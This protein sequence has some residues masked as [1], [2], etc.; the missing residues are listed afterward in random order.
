M[1]GSQHLPFNYWQKVG[2]KPI[3]LKILPWLLP[4]AFYHLVIHFAYPAYYDDSFIG[5][6]I[7][8]NMAD[9]F[10]LVFNPGELELVNTSFLY[11]FINS[12]WMIL[13]GPKIAIHITIV[14]DILM[15]T[16][17]LAMLGSLVYN[18]IPHTFTRYKSWLQI[19]LLVVLYGTSIRVTTLITAGM[20]SQLYIFFII[21]TFFLHAKG[22]EKAAYWIGA[23]I[24]LIRPE[25]VF[26]NLALGICYIFEKRKFPT[27]LAV[28]SIFVWACFLIY[29]L[30]VY[31][32]IFPLSVE[33]KRGIG[34]FTLDFKLRF[35]NQMICYQY[36]GLLKY[37]QVLL[38]ILGVYAV[39]TTSRLRPFG[40]WWLFYF[41]F[42]GLVANFHYVWY[43]TAF[44]M[45]WYSLSLIGALNTSIMLEKN[46]FKTKLIAGLNLS[47][48][49]MILFSIAFSITTLKTARRVIPRLLP[50]SKSFAIRVRQ[51]DDVALI[52]TKAPKGGYTLLEPLGLLGYAM[53]NT[54]FAD[55]PGLCSPKV[56]K[57]HKELGRLLL[58][59]TLKDDP[60]AIKNLQRNL[61]ISTIIC[62]EEDYPVLS[63]ANTFLGYKL[64]GKSIRNDYDYFKELLMYNPKQLYVYVKI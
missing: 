20:E 24:F 53:P 43:Q 19:L 18:A 29:N 61:N 4:V 37:V 42:F 46:L 35:I 38:F 11:P 55:F 22:N 12:L 28:I 40:V 58:G 30:S 48:T 59:P 3:L 62:L 14:L 54:N 5:F 2:Y 6:R 17:S 13:F 1:I 7:S 45:G 9:G 39:A 33:A 23:L 25:G 15:H 36:N 27:R 49:C 56:L 41:L 10:W 16:V 63:K 52:A 60:D 51:A 32:R 8:R 50:L 31:G 26:V 47:T 34:A 57:S 21:L 44:I 64:A